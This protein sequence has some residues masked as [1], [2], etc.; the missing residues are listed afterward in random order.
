MAGITKAASSK[1][2]SDL[3]LR[4]GLDKMV[5]EAADDLPDGQNQLGSVAGSANELQPTLIGTR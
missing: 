5:D 2:R 3:F 4:E 1:P